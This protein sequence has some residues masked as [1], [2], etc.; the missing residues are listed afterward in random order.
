VTSALAV[1]ILDTAPKS[2]PVL[3]FSATIPAVSDYRVIFVCMGNICRSPMAELV[4]RQQLAQA[5]L[6]DLVLVDSAGT[7]DWHVGDPADRRARAALERRGYPTDHAAKQ[8]EP[9]WFAER[10]LVIA[11][12]R[13]NLRE[14]KRLAPTREDAESVRLLRE[15]DA[16]AES[17]DVPDPYYGD[18]AGFDDVLDQIELSCAGLLQHLALELDAPSLPA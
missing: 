16:A 2:L 3:A 5:G 8:F 7:G 15:F 17:V 14:L 6:A 11:L 1:P 10:E 18:A 13:D 9:A 4:F 12:D